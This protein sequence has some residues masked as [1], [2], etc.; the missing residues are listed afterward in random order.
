[1]A[2]SVSPSATVTFACCPEPVGRV[3]V[4]ACGVVGAAGVAVS[5]GAVSAGLLSSGLASAG[6]SSFQPGWIGRSASKR[7][8]ESSITRPSLSLAIS[9]QRDPEP[10][11]RSAIDQRLS[12]GLLSR[13][14]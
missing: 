11:W 2:E 6:I 8:P 4:P 3:S 5:C 14:V 1:M 10:S 9:T 7:M 12:A 13:T